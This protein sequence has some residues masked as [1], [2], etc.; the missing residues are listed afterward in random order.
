[1]EACTPLGQR[2]RQTTVKSFER[3]RGN[4]IYI[5]KI[6]DKAASWFARLVLVQ[7]ATPDGSML[8]VYRTMCR[9]VA[10]SDQLW[11]A[12]GDLLY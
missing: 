10:Q 5:D 2:E 12:R 4:M 9:P 8:S 7:V 6:S 3:E 1:M 11:S